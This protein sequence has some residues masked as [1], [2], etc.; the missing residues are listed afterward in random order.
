M[1]RDGVAMI[2]CSRGCPFLCAYCSNH[3][4]AK[5]YGIRH[6]SPRFRSPESC[7][8]EIQAVIE[9]YGEL[10]KTV[11]IGDEIFGANRRWREEF[12]RMYKERIAKPYRILLRVEMVNPDL[13]TMLKESGCNLIMFGVESGNEKLRFEVLSRPVS[14]EKIIRAF[15]LC[16]QYG[17][18]TFAFN[19]IGLPG[20]TEAMIW[21]TVQ[22]NRRIRPAISI[23]AVFVP[24]RGTA[25]GERCFREGW[26][27][28]EQMLDFYEDSGET[29]L[30]FPEEHKRRLAY[31][32]ANW[33]TLVNP[34]TPE[35]AIHQRGN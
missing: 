25:L 20:E 10:V 6:N 8:R 22:L 29:L 24:L 14:D 19:M 11:F 31:F 32:Y 35:T 17:L 26:I 12:C 7:I 27:D 3:A 1:G 9:R 15:D 23:A 30:N 21:E 2:F 34:N 28:D 16:H 5:R 33:A 13:L 4:I 18:N